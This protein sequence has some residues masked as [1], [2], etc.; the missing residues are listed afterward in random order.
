MAFFVT[1]PNM[2][3]HAALMLA[4]ES[5]SYDGSEPPPRLTSG[6]PSGHKLSGTLGLESLPPFCM[7]LPFI[8]GDTDG[9]LKVATLQL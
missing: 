3:I 6:L 4:C 1:S 2:A 5:R 9:S 8:E 7:E